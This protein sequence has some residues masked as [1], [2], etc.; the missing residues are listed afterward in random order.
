MTR[1]R[2]TRTPDARLPIW[3]L[4]T[5]VAA[6]VSLFAMPGYAPA[7]PPGSEAPDCATGV[8]FL[9][10]SD[11][12]NKRTYE[13]TSVGGLSALAYTGRQST[14]YSLV[15][16]EPTASSEARLYTLRIPVKGRLGEPEI[17][18]VTTLKDASGQPF[19]AS[20][21]DGEGLTRTRRGDLLVSSE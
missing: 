7:A 8:D 4:V 20:N 5:I 11:A 1:S 16:N 9:G 14:Y 13:G 15:D 10:F 18:D 19:T 17:L 6:C 21:F 12:L 3:L 2:Q